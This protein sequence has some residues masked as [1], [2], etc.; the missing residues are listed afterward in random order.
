M[1]TGPGLVL[2]AFIISPNQET[3]ASRNIQIERNAPGIAENGLIRK[4]V[5]MQVCQVVAWII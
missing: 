5:S 4:T 3:L 2:A 1:Q